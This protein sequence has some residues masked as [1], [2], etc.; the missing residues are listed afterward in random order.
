MFSGRSS[1]WVSEQNTAGTPGASLLRVIACK[2]QGSQTIY[3]P[4]SIGGWLKAAPRSVLSPELLPAL[5]GQS[6]LHLL[7]KPSG[8]EVET[9]TA[10]GQ[11]CALQVEY[12]QGTHTMG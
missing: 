11:A 9:L 12:G 3:I 7:E 2:V 10:E 4:P 6:G 1:L 8:K 5:G